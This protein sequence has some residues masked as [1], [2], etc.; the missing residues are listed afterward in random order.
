MCQ[1]SVN[2][3]RE[4]EPPA[5]PTVTGAELSRAASAGAVTETS[6][7][8]VPSVAALELGA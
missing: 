6:G 5:A 2:D 4:K 8:A 1:T 7:C 3:A